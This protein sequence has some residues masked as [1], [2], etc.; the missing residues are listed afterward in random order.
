MKI[1]NNQCKWLTVGKTTQCNT[2]CVAEYCGTH[3]FIMR[4]TGTEP[5]PCRKCGK[6]TKAKAKLCCSKECGG[7]QASQKYIE[8]NKTAKRRYK[9]VL[10]QLKEKNT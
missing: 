5:C 7:K 6:G 10:K 8:I 3:L 4:K 9:K 2:K 1:G